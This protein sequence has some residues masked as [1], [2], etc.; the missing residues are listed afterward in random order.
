MAPRRHSGIIPS[1]IQVKSKRQIS[2]D[3]IKHNTRSWGKNT[4]PHVWKRK[5]LKKESNMLE[6]SGMLRYFVW[7]LNVSV[8][9]TLFRKPSFSKDRRQIAQI[10]KE[11]PIC[12][13]V[14]GNS[15]RNIRPQ[16][17][18]NGISAIEIIETTPA[19]RKRRE[20]RISPN[21]PTVGKSTQ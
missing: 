9:R 13:P 15:L 20:N 8:C 7:V 1:K 16:R 14:S 21:P 12:V 3:K 10:I 19:G 5:D 11:A 2:F 6:R 18:A 17:I 4:V